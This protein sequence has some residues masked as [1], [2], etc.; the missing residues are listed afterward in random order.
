MLRDFIG[1]FI[2]LAC[3]LP[4]GV[5]IPGLHA[6]ECRYAL[7][8]IFA[9]TGLYGAGLI[10]QGDDGD[11]GPAAQGARVSQSG[12]SLAETMANTKK[13]V[14]QQVRRDS[15]RPLKIA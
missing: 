14:E 3:S 5:D 6:P 12:E 8:V 10:L 9:L 11:D 15:R 13:Y 4:I 1:S 2:V 7:T